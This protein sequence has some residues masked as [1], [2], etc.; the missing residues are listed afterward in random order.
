MEYIDFAQQLAVSAGALVMEKHNLPMNAIAK[1]S[2]DVVTDADFASQKLI[3]ERIKKEFPDHGFLTEEDDRTLPTSKTVTW[4][5]DPIDGTVNFSRGQ[6]IYTVSIA[7][8]VGKELMAGVIYDPVR[9]ELFSAS[10]G[11]GFFVNDVKCE[12]SKIMGLEEAVLCLD[13]KNK[14]HIRQNN[15][16]VLNKI[17]H[18][19]RTVNILGSAT[20]ALAWVAAGRIDGYFNYDLDVWDIA[21]GSLMIREAGGQ[22]T[23]YSNARWLWYNN[24]RTC[25]ATNGHIHNN[26]ISCVAES[27]LTHAI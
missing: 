21:A 27:N 18:K 13:W 1:D 14:H 10:K 19:V 24:D 17:V 15:L 7:V 26:L 2:R 22:L 20:L 9:K 6:P 4:I 12:V 25:L 3:T 5:I 16:A 8:A 11:K 23:D